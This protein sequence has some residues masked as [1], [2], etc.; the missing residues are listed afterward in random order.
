MRYIAI[1]WVLGVGVVSAFNE[2]CPVEPEKKSKEKHVAEYK[3]EKIYFCCSSCVDEF[4]AAPEIYV[5]N[6]PEKLRLAVGG[7]K[8]D[9]NSPDTIGTAVD[10]GRLLV[11]S[12]YAGSETV[13][14][15]A[16]VA[17]VFYV[18]VLGGAFFSRK[19]EKRKRR[20][21]KVGLSPFVAMCFV[22]AAVAADSLGARRELRKYQHK[23][24]DLVIRDTL[25]FASYYE[26][27]TPL[28]V[29]RPQNVS[30]S[31]RL[32]PVYYR[33]NDE[34]SPELFN[35]GF[36]RTA[37]MS[38]SLVDEAGQ[39]VQ[40]G[41]RVDGDL[42]LKLLVER[43][44]NTPDYFFSDS[45]MGKMFLTASSEPLIGGNGEVSDRVS[46][47]AIQPNYVF[48]AKYP[49][50]ISGDGGV[51]SSVYVREDRL[52]AKKTKLGSRVHY[53]I[54]VDL[55]MDGDI[56][57]D[58][59]LIWMGSIYRTRRLRSWKIPA[60]EWLGTTPIPELPEPH[61]EKSSKLLGVDE[62]ENGTPNKKSDDT[63]R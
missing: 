44:K 57:S 55:K 19:N 20:F 27:G 49:L 2:W 36:Y 8:G 48:E 46:F 53:A 3:G 15:V 59:S 61:D 26:Y 56:L 24:E 42:Y 4:L 62:Q 58:Q 54:H 17:G 37:T 12:P 6:L 43:G 40:A 18:V 38:L 16:A 34:R 10:R 28:R 14:D 5:A 22:V 60:D 11:I 52:H 45:L 35:R 51:D 50:T 33:G 47:D 63:G 30:G 31:N 7:E 25:H 9:R 13:S 41:D 32:S 23:Y 1:F 21:L 39:E 29:E